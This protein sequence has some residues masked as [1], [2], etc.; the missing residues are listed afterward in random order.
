MPVHDW[1]RVTAGTFHDFHH[2]WIAELR[3][4]LNGGLL[5]PD[6]YALAE[7]VAGRTVPDVLTLQNLRGPLA[8]Q[9]VDVD[10]PAGG[11]TSVSESGGGGLLVA[12]APPAARTVASI[13]EAAILTLKRLRLV[14]R[15]ATDDR[16]VALIEIVSPGNKDGAGPTQMLVDKAV[17]ALQQGYHLVILDLLPPGASDPR[18]LHDRLWRELGGGGYDPP[19]GK[20]LTLAAYCAGKGVTA[21]VEPVAVGDALP[22]MPLFLEPERYV[23]VPL[24][25]TYAAAYEGVPLRW[26]RV[27]EGTVAR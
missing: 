13:S 7:Q 10:S 11:G 3:R 5:P 25:P 20:P 1:T 4:A 8:E 26:R 19:P 9:G 27:I 2:A 17:A 6:Y 15:H 18:G 12:D 16:V 21:Y 24:E 22:P 14:I 23:N